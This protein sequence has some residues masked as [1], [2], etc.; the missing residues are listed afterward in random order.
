MGFPRQLVPRRPRHE[1][2]PARERSGL[3]PVAFESRSC[4]VELVGV[5]LERDALT[6]PQ[7]VDLEPLGIRVEGRLGQ[8]RGAQEAHQQAL[9]P[10]AREGGLVEQRPQRRHADALLRAGDRA[11]DLALR[12]EPADLRLLDGGREIARREVGRDLEQGPG[13]R[14]DLDPAQLARVGTVQRGDGVDANAVVAHPAAEARHVDGARRM[15]PQLVEAEP[16]GA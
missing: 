4:R 5:E 14:A 12:D 3:A 7:R 9:G 13:G 16:R 15:R 11:G 8:P 1:V 10:R 2:L 6:P